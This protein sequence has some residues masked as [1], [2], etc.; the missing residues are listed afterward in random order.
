M[1]FT[2][3]PMFAGDLYDTSLRLAASPERQATQPVGSPFSSAKWRQM[4]DLGWQGVIVPE[5]AGGV[6]GT[7]ADLA[8]IVEA[9]ARHAVAAPLIDRCAVAPA[10]L[11]GLVA[12]PAVRDLLEAIAVGDAS[13]ATVADAS[14]RLP[15]TPSALRLSH[16]RF[17]GTLKG[18]DLSEPATHLLFN[19]LDAQT[20]EPVLVLLATEALLPRARHARG[21]DGRV[22][23]DFGLEGLAVEPAQVLLRGT[24]VLDAVAH[25]QQVGSLLTCVQAVGA[26]GAMIEQTIEYLGTRV[27]FGVQLAT[28]Q[29]LRHRVVEMYVTYENASGLVRR[30]VE[31]ATRER[32]GDARDIALVKLY[33]G[34]ASRMWSEVAIQLHGGM[35]MT[36]ETLVARLAMHSLMGSMSYGDTGQC[37]DWLTAKTVALA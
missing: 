13:V 18:V 22:N 35:G 26:A 3:T 14:E 23:A 28:F 32:L 37:L 27:Q 4:L 6:D 33:V 36:W 17:T 31:R 11:S 5:A 20:D 9:A 16:G 34:N 24:A 25:A 7:L 12:Q 29:A 1:A 19:T 21:L 30:L 10:L 8:A 2:A 15:G